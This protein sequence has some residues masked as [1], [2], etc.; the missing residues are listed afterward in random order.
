MHRL[1]FPLGAALTLGLAPFAPEPH[2]LGKLRWLAGGG[3]G[4]GAMDGF[5]LILHGAPWIW[6]LVAL[7]LEARREPAE[8]APRWM[9]IALAAAL[10]AAVLC[11]SVALTR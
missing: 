1:G 4:M 9:I 6:L 11:V 5:D 8:R 7:V 3:V 2:I 10:V